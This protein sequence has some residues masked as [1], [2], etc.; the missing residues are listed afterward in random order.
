MGV[1]LSAAPLPDWVAASDVL[2]CIADLGNL[3]GRVS[4][5]VR[6]CY[7]GLGS[8]LGSEGAR[9]PLLGAAVSRRESA[10][11]GERSRSQLLSQLGG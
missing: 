7:P 3:S 11:H 1:E 8:A 6:S 5:S 4:H 9:S 10:C 2:R